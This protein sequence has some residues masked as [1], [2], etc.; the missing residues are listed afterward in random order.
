M[1]NFYKCSEC[2]KV[3]L[4]MGAGDDSCSSKDLSLL[5]PNTVDAAMEKH[6]P[7]VSVED[8]LVTVRVGA[9]PH[10]M[11]PE[12]FIQWVYVKT[13]FG[14]VFANLSPGDP[15]QAAIHV[16]PSEVEEVYAYCNLHGLWKA[17]EPVLP[18]SFRA[19]NIACSA[20]FSDG[21]V[22]HAKG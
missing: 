9:M 20:E 2:D 6:V 11:E 15:P 1:V 7:V 5:Q 13:S 19:N 21:C 16:E 18:L 17:K 10:P 4:M 12:H 22:E 3:L 8:G 14:G